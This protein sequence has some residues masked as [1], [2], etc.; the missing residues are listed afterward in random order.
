MAMFRMEISNSNNKKNGVVPAIEK[1]EY[2]SRTG[3]YS[4]SQQKEEN[5]EV[6][7]SKSH[8]DYIQRKNLF[9]SEEYEDLLYSENGNMPSWAKDNPAFFWLAADT[10][11]GANRVRYYSFEL[12]LPQELSDEENINLVKD[13]C[14]KTFGS[15]F[16]YSYGIHKKPTRDGINT[17]IHTH[18]MFSERKLD[19][20]ERGPEQFFKRAN[21]KFPEKG[22]A[23]KDPK[24]HS[25]YMYKRERKNWEKLLNSKLKEKRL[26]IVLSCETLE[27]QLEM[28][29]SENDKMKEIILDRVPIN[30][31]GRI[32]KKIDKYGVQT[33]TKKEKIEY[34]KYLK[35]VEMRDLAFETVDKIK[36]LEKDYQ[37]KLDIFS[38]TQKII[39]NDCNQII[40]E[41]KIINY[42]NNIT[43]TEDFAF[44]NVFGIYEF[45]SEFFRDK[46][47]KKEYKFTFR[48]ALN[49]IFSDENSKIS[50]VVP[51]FDVYAA[52]QRLTQLK[53]RKD[54]FDTNF[55]TVLPEIENDV[56]SELNSYNEEKNKLVE[57]YKNELYKI[58]YNAIVQTFEKFERFTKLENNYY[59]E[60][61]FIEYQ[62]MEE[63]KNQIEQIK[64]IEESKNFFQKWLDKKAFKKP[65]EIKPLE[66]QL[67]KTRLEFTTNF[68]NAIYKDEK[69]QAEKIITMYKLAENNDVFKQKAEKFTKQM[70]ELREKIDYTTTMLGYIEKLKENKAKNKIELF[71][72]SETER[73]INSFNNFID[74]KNQLIKKSNDYSYTL[75]NYQKIISAKKTLED[76]EKL[77]E[78]SKN[79]KIK[80]L[81]LIENYKKTMLDCFEKYEK[82]KKEFYE[83][84]LSLEFI[85]KL[86]KEDRIYLKN[87]VEKNT[88][89]KSKSFWNNYRDKKVVEYIDKILNNKE[90]MIYSDIDFDVKDYVKN[91]DIDKINSK[92]EDF[93]FTIKDFKKPSFSQGKTKDTQKT[94]IPN[95]IPNSN[96]VKQD[97][98]E[99]NIYIA[100]PKKSKK[101]EKNY[102]GIELF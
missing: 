102:D 99:K 91:Y 90:T 45:E 73:K 7:N 10:Y 13:Y 42:K 1:Y 58:N 59:A 51:D 60:N 100:I 83:N 87:E 93:S 92:K 30:C 31:P 65:D 46:T 15:D 28:A 26:N 52:N 55:L 71:R 84:E 49:N 80:K 11:E 4:P 79:N 95:S 38:N 20:I 76:S 9:S 62:K 89:I 34:D 53:Y 94:I 36:K 8:L 81:E 97:G 35:A 6:V 85:K 68:M 66:Q 88:L 17:N 61:T 2:D 70:N 12:A 23:K 5:N 39:E 69:I 16:V 75:M 86:S 41:K 44:N 24:W 27:K 19:G 82:H 25:I 22:G 37:E 21:S 96:S 72:T 78:L 56:K 98:E 32:L 64:A 3:K 33:L 54:K 63:I 77:D 48:K 14:N 47:F 57:E 18:I 67:E 43:L 40:L 50:F 74:L 101:K 29:K